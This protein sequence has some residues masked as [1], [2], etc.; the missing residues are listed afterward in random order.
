MREVPRSPSPRALND[1]FAEA[2]SVVFHGVSAGV[3]DSFDELVLGLLGGVAD[4]LFVV[5]VVVWLGLVLGLVAGHGYVSLFWLSGWCVRGETR[6][7]S[8]WMDAG[9]DRWRAA[10]FRLTMAR[11]RGFVARRA[12]RAW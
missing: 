3:V 1:G 2:V 12:R 4:Q 6:G 7:A 11:R 5:V 9:R 8:V 10:G